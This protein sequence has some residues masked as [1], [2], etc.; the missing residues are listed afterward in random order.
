MWLD[1]PCNY[2]LNSGLPLTKRRYGRLQL[3]DDGTLRLMKGY[4]SSRLGWQIP[5]TDVI[6]VDVEG[7]GRITS[8][9]VIYTKQENYQVDMA[10]KQKA[11][12]L[13]GIFS[14]LIDTEQKRWYHDS[15]QLTH[16]E[17]Y[18]YRLLLQKDV[19]AAAH[20]GWVPQTSAAI[21]GQTRIAGSVRVGGLGLLATNK[22]LDQIII[23]FGRTPEWLS[24]NKE[25][26]DAF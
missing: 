19:E 17:T 8:K 20:Y 6:K 16:V 23:T 24:Q 25:K 22:D 14:N 11:T 1:I 13:L 10:D 9:I 18:N 15:T 5:Y 26:V 4:A 12:I 21:G 2:K 3:L 7:R